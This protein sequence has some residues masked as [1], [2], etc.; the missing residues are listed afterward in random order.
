MAWRV[1]SATTIR[2]WNRLSGNPN[3]HLFPNQTFVVDRGDDL[4]I[5]QQSAAA[6][7]VV[8]QSEYVHILAF[9]S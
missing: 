1:C 8:A 5:L 6:V 4:I 2:Y 7:D 9:P 3:N